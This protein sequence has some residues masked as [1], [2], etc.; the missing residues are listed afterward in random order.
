MKIFEIFLKN[1]DFY[2]GCYHKYVMVA[3]NA[4]SAFDLAMHIDEYGN[5]NKRI[6]NYIAK[7]FY[8]VKVIGESN[9]SQ[10]RFVCGYYEP[11][12]ESKDE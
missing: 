6:V 11:Y 7:D 2:D 3:E 8:E 5:I 9:E 1:P 10:P 12:N 4:E